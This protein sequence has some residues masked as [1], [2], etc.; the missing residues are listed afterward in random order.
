MFLAESFWIGLFGSLV[1]GVA[2]VA[3]SAVA[4]RFGADFIQ[5]P[6][7]FRIYPEAIV[8]GAALGLVVSMV[9]GLL[10]VLSAAKVR[11]AVILRPD[12]LGQHHGGLLPAPAGNPLSRLRPRL[13]RRGNPARSH[14]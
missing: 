1:G 7:I 13:D 3:L 11:P 4:N 14:Q 10:P 12:R 2:G 5:Q 8:F 9:F 6:L